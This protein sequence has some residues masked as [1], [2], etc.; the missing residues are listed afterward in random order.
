MLV[1][2]IDALLEKDMSPFKRLSSLG[3]GPGGG[4]HGK[5]TVDKANE[6]DCD[7]SGG[8]CVCTGKGD[9]KGRTKTFKSGG[10]AATKKQY[11]IDYKQHGPYKRRRSK[12]R[13]ERD[14]K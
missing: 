9:K 3:P 13:A 5:R 2:Y 8:E 10:K 11:N 6:W 14:K 7:C 4:V 12:V 1:D